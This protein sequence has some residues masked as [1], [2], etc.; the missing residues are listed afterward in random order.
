MHSS[1]SLTLGEFGHINVSRRKLWEINVSKGEVGE[2]D[3]KHQC[4]IKTNYAHWTPERKRRGV[5]LAIDDNLPNK[6]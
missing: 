6:P 4:T 1:S 3:N 2:V 5:A